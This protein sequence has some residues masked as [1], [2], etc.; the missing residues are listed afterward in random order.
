MNSCPFVQWHLSLS[1]TCAAGYAAISISSK[2]SLNLRGQGNHLGGGAVVPTMLHTTCYPAHLH[3][4]NPQSG[5]AVPSSCHGPF[6][7]RGS[8][9]TSKGPP[10]E[11]SIPSGVLPQRPAVLTAL[12]LSAHTRPAS[13]GAERPPLKVAPALKSE[14]VLLRR[15]L[16]FAL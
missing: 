1:S 2:P 13:Q 10:M 9:S 14:M 16:G 5:R 12:L 7:G 15:G 6:T 3:G 8:G 4:S 11:P